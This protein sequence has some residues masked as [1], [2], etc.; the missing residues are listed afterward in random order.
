M[1]SP[2]INEKE[3]IAYYDNCQID[4]ELVWQLDTSLCMHYGYWD[5]K[6]KSHGDAVKRMNEKLAEYANI[7]PGDQ[8]LDAGCGVGGS[9]IYLAQNYDCEVVGITLSEKQVETC[10]LNAANHGVSDKVRF[11]KQNYLKT[12][13]PDQSFDVVWAIESVC[14]A[15][16]KADF[17]KEAF[18]LLKPGGRIVVAD[19]FTNHLT[20]GTRGFKLMDKWTDTWAIKAYA[21]TDVFRNDLMDIGYEDIE[22]REV[23]NK[24]YKSIRR[25]KRSFYPG[26]IVTTVSQV[27]GFR[28]KIQTGNTWSTWYQWKAYKRGLWHY[29]MI[30]AKKPG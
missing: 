9:S 11:E 26:L 15:W 16:D 25:L 2:V 24:V 18:R 29:N 3:I 5:E 14:Y 1:E 4:Y 8:I 30:S 17:L 21:V 6:T 20:P 23:T 7:Q 12:S 10:T 19:F 28:N 22:I 27:L 13:F